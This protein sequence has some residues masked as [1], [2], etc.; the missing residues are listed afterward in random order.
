MGTCD[1]HRPFAPDLSAR[2][3]TMRAP[4]G[5][6]PVMSGGHRKRIRTLGRRPPFPF[7]LC[8]GAGRAAH[9]YSRRPSSGSTH[10][11]GHWCPTAPPRYPSSPAAGIRER[12]GWVPRLGI[13]IARGSLRIPRPTHRLVACVS[14]RRARVSGDGDCVILRAGTLRRAS[15]VGR[16]TS[17]VG[18]VSSPSSSVAWIGI[19]SQG[20]RAS[21]VPTSCPHTARRRTRPESPATRAKTDSPAALAK[22]DSRGRIVEE[23]RRGTA[24]E[25]SASSTSS[26]SRQG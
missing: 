5:R 3:R 12:C 18:R 22:A 8:A 7:N 11:C 23:A 2:P 21:S 10:G 13:D 26:S 16:R 24:R 19:E 14:S 6:R 20:C 15:G 9:V 1:V 17:D 25:L 4:S